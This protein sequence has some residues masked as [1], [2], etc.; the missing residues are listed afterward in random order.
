MLRTHHVQNCGHSRDMSSRCH[1]S[2]SHVHRIYNPKTARNA[3]PLWTHTMHSIHM[4]Y[5]PHISYASLRPHSIPHTTH[6][7]HTHARTHAHPTGRLW[8]SYIVK[9]LL[10]ER[11]FIPATE[12]ASPTRP[13]KDFSKER[14]LLLMSITCL[15]NSQ[16]W[17][18]D[19]TQGL[20]SI[21]G[22]I[23][24]ELRGLICWVGRTYGPLAFA[25]PVPRSESLGR[26]A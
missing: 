16:A 20:T 8:A 10:G 5:I 9:I 2:T 6:T 11:C 1:F 15:I 14:S 12:A 26:S 22:K 23:N 19:R 17:F 24:G 18:E 3:H 7:S 25:H 13:H 4:I 21:Q